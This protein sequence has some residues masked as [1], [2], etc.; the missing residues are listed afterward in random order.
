[1]IYH[2][3]NQNQQDFWYLK[4]SEGFPTVS[5][6]C[7]RPLGPWLVKISGIE[8]RLGFL[9]MGIFFSLLSAF[10]LMF[11]LK[12]KGYSQKFSLASAIVWIAL[13]HSPLWTSLLSVTAD[14]LA[15]AFG[16]M[17]LIGIQRKDKLGCAIA[18]VIGVM[19][20]ESVLLVALFALWKR[21]WWE[22]LFFSGVVFLTMLYLIEPV[23]GNCKYLFGMHEAFFGVIRN[24]FSIPCG[25]WLAFGPL[26]ALAW[27][28]YG[29]DKD[30]SVLLLLEL[31]PLL[32]GGA[33]RERFLQWIPVMIPMGLMAFI[34]SEKFIKHLTIFILIIVL[35]IV[36][37]NPITVDGFFLRSSAGH[38]WPFKVA[39]TC[40]MFYYGLVIFHFQESK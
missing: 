30:F 25:L 8:P 14:P 10:L 29:K 17:G 15:I 35:G 21:N 4:A 40:M 23:P 16:L 24:P 36:N 7:Y 22:P 31:L 38:L 27:L 13:P 39:C 12:E 37:S 32:L 28:E 18:L 20:R 9:L 6:Q 26:A 1:M 5:P 3:Y 11:W 34:H 33:D 19:A 2:V